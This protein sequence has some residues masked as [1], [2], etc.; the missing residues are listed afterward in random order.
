MAYRENMR[1]AHG[2]PDG[3]AAGKN[4]RWLVVLAS[5]AAVAGLIW[6]VRSGS[7]LK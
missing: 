6:F 7:A 1:G 2:E 5:L 4:G 3:A